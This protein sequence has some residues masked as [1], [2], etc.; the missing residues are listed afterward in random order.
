MQK[1]SYEKL[2]GKERNNR[3][4]ELMGD[5]SENETKNPLTGFLVEIAT[6]GKQFYAIKKEKNHFVISESK[7]PYSTNP[8][9]YQYIGLNDGRAK[10]KESNINAAQKV[11]KFI[12]ES[13]NGDEF[14]YLDAKN[15]ENIEPLKEYFE[16]KELIKEQEQTQAP[17]S[18]P[19]QPAQPQQPSEDDL[20][21]DDLLQDDPIEEIKSMAG[22]LAY[23]VRENVKELSPDTTKWMLKSI[24]SA[25][26]V[27]SIDMDTRR[28]MCKDML[29]ATPK[30]QGPVD[31]TPEISEPTEPKRQEKLNPVT[32]AINS[33]V[34]EKKIN[35][36][37]TVKVGEIKKQQK[38][39]VS[40]SKYFS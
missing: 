34:K 20:E 1:Y 23:L 18:K 13:I 40:S 32:E 24:I 25:S 16:H 2:E 5:L 14:K 6:N 7:V 12:C 35:E 4:L 37:L 22:K 21:L 3:L 36:S 29:K 19:E 30:S 15:F 27:G 39:L 10:Y 9:D 11:L 28:E 31:A 38:G 8:D 33:I 17:V 26:D